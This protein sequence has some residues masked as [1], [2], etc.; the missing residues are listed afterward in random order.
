VKT[1]SGT[2]EARFGDYVPMGADGAI[3]L[4]GTIEVMIPKKVYPFAVK[5]ETGMATFTMDPDTSKI[6]E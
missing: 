4:P 3:D 5:E 2:I 1:G 6:G